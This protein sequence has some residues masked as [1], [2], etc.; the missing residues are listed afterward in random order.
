MAMIGVRILA[1]DGRLGDAAVGELHPDRIGAGDHVL[2]GDDGALRIHDDAGAQTALDALAVARPIIAEQLIERR[3]LAA[4]GDDARGVD[5]DHR[6]RR[7]CHRV[8]EALHDDTG[9][10]AAGAGCGRAPA[11]CGA[12]AGERDGAR[13]KQVSTRRLGRRRPGRPRPLSAKNS[14]G[15]RVFCNPI[16][17]CLPKARRY[18]CIMRP[19]YSLG[20]TMA[21][22]VCVKICQHCGDATSE[23][24]GAANER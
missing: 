16:S 18:L 2:I 13:A 5:V 4:L 10:T 22:G 17:S 12:V 15:M 6:R 11:G 14:R 19:Q 23:N 7:A 24:M 21:T 20:N 3:R 8:G 1:D 9:R